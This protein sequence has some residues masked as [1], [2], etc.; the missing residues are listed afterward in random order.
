MERKAHW[1]KVYGSRAPDS[2]SWYQKEPRKSLE[3]IKACAVSGAVIDVGGGASVLVDRL[4]ESGYEVTVL[5][6]SGKALFAAK[7]RLRAAAAKVKWVEGDVTAV[8]LPESAY[9]VWHDRAVFHFLTEEEDRHKY[10]DQLRYALKPGGSVVMACFSLAGPPK[11]SGLDV[12]RY[13]SETLSKELGEDFELLDAKSETHLTPF[14]T[15]QQFVYCR[16]RR[17]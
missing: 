7:D 16:F 11:C 14:K 4:V 8:E 10:L 6:I 15:T 2:V 13:S 12:A 5:D 9:D 3:L 17:R 1:E